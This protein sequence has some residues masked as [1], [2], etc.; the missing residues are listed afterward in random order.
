[1]RFS[2]IK[3]KIAAIITGLIIAQ[4]LYYIS[5]S[6]RQ[7]K[8]MG[9]DILKK[10]AEFIANL[11]AENLALGI[12]TII[13]DEGAALEQ[14]LNIIKNRKNKSNTTISKVKVFD[15]NLQFMKGINAEPTEKPSF[16]TSNQLTFK[17][18]SNTLH[19]WS[20][21][22]NSED[23]LL[24]YV[25]IDF[26]KSF[27]MQ[28]AHKNLLTS[29]FTTILAI[30]LSIILGILFVRK[31]I[32]QIE[33]LALAAKQISSGDLNVN[34]E[35]NS[36]DEIGTLAESFQG[37]IQSQR[38]KADVAK[39]ISQGNLNV[40]VNVISSEDTLGLAMNNMKQSIQ[41]LLSDVNRLA[42]AAL[43]G[44]LKTRVNDS[45]HH[46]DFSKIVNGINQILEAVNQPFQET[47]VVMEKIAS[48]DLVARI[49]GN[50]NGDYEKLKSSVNTALF[51]LDESMQRV[52][53]SADKVTSASS[54]INGG[55][56]SLAEGASQQ[57]S[58]LQE[59]SSNLQEMSSMIKKNADNA[60][61][62]M[63]I[64]N[65]ASSKT[66]EGVTSMHR[67]SEAIQKIKNS[68]DETAKIVKTIDDIAFQTNLLALNAAVEAARAGDAGKGF[69][70]VA[71]EVRNLAMRS[72][73]AAKDTSSMID[74]SINNANSG[75][76]LN[77]EVLKNLEEINKQINIVSSV[78]SEIAYASGQ[79]SMGI[80]QVNMNVEHMNQ[81]TQSTAAS[82]EQSA[83]TAQEMSQQANEMHRMVA[84]FKLSEQTSSMSVNMKGNISSS[85]K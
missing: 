33:K 66:D 17:D 6:P 69:A 80:D 50:Y 59:I 26:S 49:K 72:A 11:L 39:Q 36:E 37:I 52:A 8:K 19:V 65:I 73:Q 5:M 76:E 28:R 51:N 32:T 54:Q 30:S 24:G 13:I 85:H 10:D 82:A 34:V 79:Q 77:Q 31:M 42:E 38:E 55:S 78:V 47:L 44:N 67:L 41:N 12:E 84:S 64:S 27:L 74:D 53:I 48:K 45:R 43:A 35:I 18:N 62:A 58:S 25:E 60:K 83:S 70:V 2:S 46:G 71:E 1:M 15:S 9:N 4:N 81:I 68:S 14:S 23:N 29:I 40:Q 16:K 21:I 7:A 56:Q 20:P 61:E 3:F 22:Y 57:A 75:V 63:E